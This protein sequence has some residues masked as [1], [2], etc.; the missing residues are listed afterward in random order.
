MQQRLLGFACSLLILSAC[1]GGSSDNTEPVIGPLAV[2]VVS[3]PS[4]SVAVNGTL[5]LTA[6]GQDASA[7]VISGTTFTWTSSNNATATVNSSGLVSGLANGP[8]TITATATGTTFSG[9][10]SLT[11][12]VAPGAAS[13]AATPSQSFDPS[14]VDIVAGGTVTWNFGALTHNV[15][16][17]GTA[18]GTPQNTGD[19]TN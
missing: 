18:T 8:V 11:V 1:G 16:F 3:A 15:T 12:A 19:Q 4:A 9:T 10:K 14:Q 2:V 17:N 5:Q 7:H 6:V 13:V